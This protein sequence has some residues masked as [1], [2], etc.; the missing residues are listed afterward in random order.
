MNTKIVLLTLCS[1]AYSSII[2]AKQP[3]VYLLEKG[4]QAPF[5]GFIFDL[6]K[7]A[8]IRSKLEDY[9]LLKEKESILN[10]EI[11]NY[12]ELL[13]NTEVVLK[14]EQEKTVIWKNSAEECTEKY[15]KTVDSR[16]NRDMMFL[17][18]GVLLTLTSSYIVASVFKNKE[19]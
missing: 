11:I 10:S 3:Q 15:I 7:E 18:F 17:G 5:R 1:F 2:F 13:E 6:Y 9:K 8:E 14:K 12:K 16:S 4:Q 19:K